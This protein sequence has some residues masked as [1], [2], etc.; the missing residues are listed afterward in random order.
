[1]YVEPSGRPSPRDPWSFR[2]TGVEH[3][4]DS[5]NDRNLIVLLHPNDRAAAQGRLEELADSQHR[6]NLIAHP[7]HAHL[8]IMSS[9]LKHWQEYL[10]CLAKS[11]LDIVS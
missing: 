2:Q 5:S 3:L 9:Y 11:V 4:Y 6:F 1:M 8:V 10:E 7:L